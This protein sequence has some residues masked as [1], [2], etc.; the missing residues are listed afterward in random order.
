MGHVTVSVAN[1]YARHLG[2]IYT[3]MVGDVDAALSRS[4]EALKGRSDRRR[5]RPRDGRRFRGNV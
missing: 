2:P 4:D 3:W 1:H 5:R